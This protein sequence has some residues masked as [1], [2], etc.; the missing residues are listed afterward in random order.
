MPLEVLVVAGVAGQIIAQQRQQGGVLGGIFVLIVGYFFLVPVTNNYQFY[1]QRKTLIP[2]DFSQEYSISMG[3]YQPAKLNAWRMQL[4]HDLH[5]QKL[6]AIIITEFY[7]TTLNSFLFKR[8]VPL[9]GRPSNYRVPPIGVIA[10]KSP[11]KNLKRLNL[12]ITDY[13]LSRSHPIAK[14]FRLKFFINPLSWPFWERF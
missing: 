11:S 10:T 9:Q 6:P 13:L 1:Q 3:E 14:R 8:L 7:K 4:S 5:R 2:A 12:V